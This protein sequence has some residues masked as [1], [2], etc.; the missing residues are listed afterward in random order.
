LL[1]ISSIFG[2]GQFYYFSKTEEKPDFGGEYIEGII[3]QPS[4]INPI[5]SQSNETDE[6]LVQL[7]Y[8]GLFKYDEKGNLKNDLAESYEISDDKTTYTVKLKRNII[9]HDNQPLTA[10]DV[11]FTLNL[12]SDPAYKSPLRSSWK[13]IEFQQ[14]DDF[15]LQF[16]INEPYAGF[17]HSLTFK[18]LPK[19]IWESV[20]PENFSLSP[21]N[22]ETIG[23]GPYKYNTIQK[24]SKGNILTYKLLANPFYF[25]GKPY[26][27][28]IT[29][30][31]Y[32]DED[33][34]LDALNRKEIMGINSLS[35]QKIG[36]IKSQKNISVYKVN[37]PRYLAVFFNQNKS[38]P[39]ANDEV[40]KALN[41]AT[42]REEILGRVLDNNGHPVYSPFLEGTLGYSN[43]LGE[44]EFNP[45][46]A[47]NLLEE[48][49]W[50][51]NDS[52]IRSKDGTDLKINLVTTD[53]EE[54]KKTSE[55]LKSQWEKIGAEVNIQSF[56]I[57]DIQQ[58]YIRPREYEAFL[59]GQINGADP[60][61]YSFWH[62][63][64]KN[65]PGLNL[66]RF[67]DAETDKIIEQARVEFDE[68]KR[69]Q[70]YIDFQ[71]K[72]FE[73]MPAV[74]LYSPDYIYPVSNSIKNVNLVFMLNPSQRFSDI[75]LWYIKT[76][77][78]KK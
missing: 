31:F 29:F 33:S 61:P 26:I 30:N 41:L 21:L 73:E 39:L 10:N 56:S 50:K 13:K 57:S 36:A 40:R 76:K 72:L 49:G 2:W 62:S 63:D 5:L 42:N 75:N 66:S 78:V 16:K 25:E 47:N 7:I 6:D 23:S 70:A 14:L 18:I 48:K 19:H 4:H 52:G 12:I 53:W 34:T 8:S 58:N 64:Q 15:S 51:K 77:R 55:I 45:E 37:L 22:L 17:L 9:W 59:F 38:V 71:K 60:D 1:L 27:S 44:K 68:E 67:G 24:D 69:T 32:T 3:G 65:D 20:S 35:S 74:F 54:L 43:E 28:K 11:I 46:K